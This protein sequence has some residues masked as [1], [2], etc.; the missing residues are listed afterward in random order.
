MNILDLSHRL[1]PKTAPYPG[2]DAPPV[3]E[4]THVLERDKFN[5]WTVSLGM[6]LGTHV[7]VP[8]HLVQDD[9]WVAD[10]DLSDF[11][12]QGQLIWLPDLPAKAP[13]TPQ[14]LGD[15]KAP[16]VLIA[17]GWDRYLE[18]EPGRYF[19]EHPSL[20]LEAAEHLM[21]SGVRLLGLDSP[22]PDHVPFAAHRALLRQGVPIVENLRGLSA[23]RG[24]PRFTF[25]APPL[26]IEAEASLV[27]AF[28]LWE[29]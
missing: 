16:V 22:S 1:S 3:F 27:R 8:M 7:D 23:L 15:I 24:V 19:G 29:G 11:C 20:T 12:G 4:H 6:H 14:M 2:G 18:A 17:T 10:F 25:F 9:R 28:A 13:I 26:K 5:A 21:G